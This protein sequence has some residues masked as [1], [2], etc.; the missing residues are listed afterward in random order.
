VDVDVEAVEGGPPGR[1]YAAFLIFVRWAETGAF[2]GVPERAYLLHREGPGIETRTL[3]VLDTATGEIVREADWEVE[4]SHSGLT[5]DARIQF[6]DAEGEATLAAHPLYPGAPRWEFPLEDEPPGRVC[7]VGF[8]DAVLAY[9]DRV[10]I[11]RV[12]LDAEHLP[13]GRRDMLHDPNTVPD[14]AV[15]SVIALD[16]ATGEEVWRR[17]GAPEDLRYPDRPGLGLPVH[18]GAGPVIL[19]LGE[20]FDL[21]TGAPVAVLPA[22]PEEP[23]ESS[24]RPW[25]V[26]TAGAVTLRDPGE[27]EPSLVLRTDANG[28]VVQRIEGD[29]TLLH[30]Q[31]E[32]PLPLAETVVAPVAF[33]DRLPEGARAVALLPWA[34]GLGEDDVEWVELGMLSERERGKHR[35]VAVPGSVVSYVQDSALPLYGLVP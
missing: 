29:R 24:D 31:L 20:V 18:E 34:E 28:E 30:H 9:G 12:C 4:R 13:E 19:A 1:A 10:L 6:S 25:S 3:V 16:A 27:E 2:L 32:N 26:D 7:L 23:L 11:T 21:A 22:L 8:D 17:T 15:E 35:V 5:L 33:H 14:D